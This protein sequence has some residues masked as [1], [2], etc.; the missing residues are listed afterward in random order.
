ML[1]GEG[2]G[3]GGVVGCWVGVWWGWLRAGRGAVGCGRLGEGSGG[4]GRWFGGAGCGMEGGLRG[5]EGLGG[6]KQRGAPWRRQRGEKKEDEVPAQVPPS[7]PGSGSAP[8]LCP[9]EAAVA[10]GC[11]TAL[12]G[13]WP[14]ATRGAGGVRGPTLPNPISHAVWDAALP[15]S[16]RARSSHSSSAEVRGIPRAAGQT[17][18]PLPPGTW[19]GP[20]VK[21]KCSSWIPR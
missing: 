21:G 14:A 8:D 12:L 20:L 2:L 16:L 1:G 5:A 11:P 7:L 18:Q 15:R 13:P 19:R 6:A 9:T 3:A 10:P 4:A 17:L